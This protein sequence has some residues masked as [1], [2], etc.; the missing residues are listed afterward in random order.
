MSLQKP[1]EAQE[2]L[3]ENALASIWMSNVES[4]ISEMSHLGS[5]G[6]W[7]TT[8]RLHTKAGLL[9]GPGEPSTGVLCLFEDEYESQVEGLATPSVASGFGGLS[10][11]QRLG[12]IQ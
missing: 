5:R 3:V 12:K 2:I 4:A 9:R 6:Q 8:D 10:L 1:E 7:H 11:R